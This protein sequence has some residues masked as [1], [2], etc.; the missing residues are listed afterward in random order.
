MIQVRVHGCVRVQGRYALREPATVRAAVKAAGGFGG[1]GMQP[2]GIISIRSPKKS[3]VRYYQRRTLNYKR[4]P[5]HLDVLLKAQDAIIVQFDIET[6]VRPG[7]D[8]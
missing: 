7:Q 2:T 6:W 3:D 8:A 4:H 5:A 1:Q